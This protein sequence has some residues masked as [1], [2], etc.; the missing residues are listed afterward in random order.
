MDNQLTLAQFKEALPT[1]NRGSVTQELVDQINNTFADDDMMATYQENII[2]FANVMAEGKF[3]MKKYLEAVKYVGFKLMNMTNQQAYQ[4][5]FPAKFEQWQL[6]GYSPKDISAYVAGY[7]GNKLVNL[8]YAQALVPTYIVNAPLFQQALNV[9]AQIMN[10]DDAS[11]KVRSDAANSIMTHLKRPEAAK[12]ELSV[13]VDEG[14][15]IR[16]LNSTLRA[17]SEQ[18]AEMLEARTVNAKDVAHSTLMIENGEIN[19]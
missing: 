9:Q 18:Q 13:N 7:N 12:M 5:T 19:G 8:I 3:Q 16:D 1:G 10:N 4:A 11:F 2:G 14:S 6:A 17:L 15:T